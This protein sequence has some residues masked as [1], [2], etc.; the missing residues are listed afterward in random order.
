MGNVKVTINRPVDETEPA[1]SIYKGQW[2][3][4]ILSSGK[5]YQEHKRQILCHQKMQKQ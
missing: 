1:H 2:I 4:G 3:D 5:L